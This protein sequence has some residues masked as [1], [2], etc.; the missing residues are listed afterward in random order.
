MDCLPSL[1]KLPG[2]ERIPLD[3][4]DQ[5]EKIRGLVTIKS[6]LVNGNFT[7]DQLASV[8]NS[9][10]IINSIILVLIKAAFEHRDIDK[11]IEREDFKKLQ[12]YIETEG[13]LKK[14]E[15]K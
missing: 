7:I 10:V 8:K 1:D 5:C 11:C 13:S 4:L 14:W 3:L 6:F 2:I 9:I 15:R 12:T